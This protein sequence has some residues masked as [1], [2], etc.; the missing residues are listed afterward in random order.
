MDYSPPGSSVHGVSQARIL[1]WVAISRIE[2][3]SPAGQVDSLPLS[4]LGSPVFLSLLFSCWVV[5]DSVTSWTAIHRASLPFTISWSLLKLISTESVMPSNRLILCHY[6][7]LLLSIFPSI[8]IFSNESAL[9]IRWPEYWA[10]ALASVLPMNIQ[11]WFPLG[12]AGL[13]SLLS[14]G[15]S[16]VFSS[17][18]IQK[19]QFF[20]AQ[21]SLWSKSHI[22]A[23]LLGKL[24]LWL[25]GP[26]L[27]KWYL[28]F[29]IH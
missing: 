10:S 20:S 21:P 8:R 2:P 9:L 18:T 16:R 7:L 19:H 27:V 14:K 28:C 12:L 25:Y 3:E 5:S 11:G 17:T 6:H 24:S 22:H 4:H 1:E 23:G 15:L 26:F 13:I 29:L